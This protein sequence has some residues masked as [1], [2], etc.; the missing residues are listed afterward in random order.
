[1][2]SQ[3]IP[4]VRPADAVRP[5]RS[6]RSGVAELLRSLCWVGLLL[7]ALIAR[8][9]TAAGP[10]GVY[11]FRSYG[12]DQGLRNQAVTSLAQDREG[13]LYVGTEDGLF[14]YDGDRFVHMGAAEGL[15]SEGVTLLHAGAGHEMWVATEK[16]LVGWNG[17]SR[18]PGFSTVLLPTTSVTGIAT[19][20]NGRLLVSTASG[21]FEGDGRRLVPVSGLP[22][23]AGAAWLSSDANTSYYVVAGRLHRRVHGAWE[24]QLLPTLAAGEAMQAIV[25]DARGRV[26]I[27]GRQLLLRAAR[28]GAPFED[29]TAQLPGA[30]VQKGELFLDATG[31]VWA[32]TNRGI[33]CF[34]GDTRLLIDTAHGLPNEWA[35]T[36]LVDREGSLWVGS[37]GVQQ[38]QG[39]MAWTSFTRRQGLPSDT[40]WGVFRDRAGSLWAATNRGVAHTVDAGWKVLADTQERSFYA[41]AESVDGDLWI[42]GNSGHAQHNTLLYRA[43]GSDDF[44]LVPLASVDGPSTVNSLAYG[45]DGALYI[46]TFADGLQRAIREGTGFRF[47]S[48]ALPGGATD[49][50]I[51]QLAR[52][53]R[54]RL[55]AAGM[56]GLA[57]F[58]GTHW[59]RYGA[60]DR[61]R[62]TQ[63]ETVSAAGDAVWVSYWNA[64]GVSKVRVGEDGSLQVQHVTQPD[65]LVGDTIYSAGQVP[66][67]ALWLGTAMGIKRWHAGRI[68]HFGRGD[69]LPG[70][71]AAANGFWSDA[72]GDVWFGMANGLA[73]FSA[74]N[75]PG[76][77]PTPPTSVTA[78]QDGQ[79]RAL[80]A[81]VPQVP[82]KDR[83]LTFH[84]A[85]L[86]FAQPGD[87]HRQVRMAGF[88][89]A[90]RDTAVSEARY[91]GLLPGHYRFQARAR[92]GDGAYGTVAS[93]ELVILPPWWLTWWF[94]A[95]VLA[96]LALLSRAIVRWRLARL[97]ARNAELEAL[98]GKRTRDLKAAYVALEEASMVDPLTGLKNRRYLSVF[99]PEE[100]A[101]CLRQQ[102]AHPHASAPQAAAR[103]VD[104]CLLM[105][106]LD[107]FK[108]VNDTYGHAAGDAVL[109]QLGDVLRATCRDSDVIVRWGGEE[110]LI[111]AR[112]SD[113]DQ[114]QTM[115]SQLCESVRNHAFELADGTL[116]H[117]TCSVGFTGFPLLQD[118]PERFGWEQAI[119]LADQCLYAAKHSGRD[120]WVGCLLRAGDADAGQQVRDVP[121]FGKAR[122]LT[123][124]ASP[125]GL[126]WQH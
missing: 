59:R 48:V 58:D 87:V 16:G 22:R 23:E 35:T 124:F 55:W 90:W 36:L 40:V 79:G 104:L 7:G 80:T 71:D 116:L 107:D 44:R 88:E 18:D 118:S 45:P 10:S 74:S 64:D 68:D 3:F 78:I 93:R 110:F 61:L 19:A 29:L 111:L 32:P 39:R 49:E 89:D 81:P 4:A 2:A 15:P 42:G 47:E 56:R 98:V 85:T 77:L 114:I 70:D 63:I 101:R 12:P 52:D 66:P 100:L 28:F 65:A 46:A 69:G 115:A 99:M 109:H 54:G 73:H 26:W 8:A 67:D 83:A 31:R 21:F 76:A 91:T 102:R 105:L 122:V 113:R 34:D 125:S 84:F 24:S 37:E 96:S 30:A 121:G 38:L 108:A 72:D 120:G 11:A 6:Q 9:A 106:D 50:Q 117:K 62:E 13:F 1:V 43:H 94:L 97:R 75:D 27:R 95:L 5:L 103:N 51:N 57:M 60:K 82:W 123:S 126:T 17:L 86:G 33:A 119:E 25:Q 20:A 92:Y 14:R 53:D 112:N 41:F